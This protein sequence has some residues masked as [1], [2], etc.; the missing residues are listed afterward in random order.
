MSPAV[1]VTGA[2]SG[3]GRAC[4]RAL[5]GKGYRVFAG[6]RREADADALRGECSDRVTPVPI[7][8]LQDDVVR[9]A[10]LTVATAI[11]DAGL[12]GLAGLV[13]N[14]GIAVGGPL[15]F[16]P[17][18]ALR[19]QLEV[20]VVGTLGVT[21]A[22]LPLLRRARG[23]IINIG[24]ISGLNAVPFVGA[25][26]MSKFALEAMTDALRMELKSAG[27]EVVV[28]EPGAVATPIWDR[29]IAAAD[30]M[31]QQ[32]PPE[33]ELYYGS[34]AQAMRRRAAGNAVTGMP[35]Q[36]VADVVVRALTAP[37]PRTRYLLGGN[38]WARRLLQVLPDRLR[39]RFILRAV[40]GAGPS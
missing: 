36:R 39:D 7:D 37:R 23:R 1:V 4:A 33:A 19:R 25:Y 11:D 21:Q 2:S 6:Y 15:E 38:A 8:L 31:L 22:F 40:T 9:V 10:A 14:A 34:A 24:S 26:A 12:A 27:V 35:A 13:N 30:A 20:N 17:L 16:L 5:D 28:I 18:D 29:S 3:I 32:L